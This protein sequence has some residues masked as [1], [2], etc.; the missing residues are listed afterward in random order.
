[1]KPA[2]FFSIT[3]FCLFNQNQP[4]HSTLQWKHACTVFWHLHCCQCTHCLNLQN[5][6]H[7]RREDV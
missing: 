5:G 4:E 2:M 6:L 1:M 7:G 3:N